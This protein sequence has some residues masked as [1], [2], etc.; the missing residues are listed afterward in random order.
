MVS[1]EPKLFMD[2][3]D[4]VSMSMASTQKV[5]SLRCTGIPYTI[6]ERLG[7]C[8]LKMPVKRRGLVQ[9]RERSPKVIVAE[10]AP[11]SLGIHIMAVT[12]KVKVTTQAMLILTIMRPFE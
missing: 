4:T 8:T 9:A 7:S 12:K 11:A 6:T 5:I 2:A 10:S 1:Q 3:Q